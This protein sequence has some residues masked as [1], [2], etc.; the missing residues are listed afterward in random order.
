MNNENVY[1][2]RSKEPIEN[3]LLVKV[4]EDNTVAVAGVGDTA[5]GAV[6][7]NRMALVVDVA[8]NGRPRIKAA[9]DIK[10]GECVAI[11]E[12]GKVS[13]ATAGA[14]IGVALNDGEKDSLVTVL[15]TTGTI[16]TTTV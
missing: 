2:F 14:Y 4:I 6:C 11:A 9:G 3:N 13:K 15:L 5:I 10:A 7:N 12:G 1:S 8:T 16:T